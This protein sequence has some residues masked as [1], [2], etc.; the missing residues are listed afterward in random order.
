MNSKN[1]QCHNERTITTNVTKDKER[2]RMRLQD[3]VGRCKKYFLGSTGS[4]TC[5]EGSHMRD[6]LNILHI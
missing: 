6:I 4:G 5:K 3:V 2:A 1:F